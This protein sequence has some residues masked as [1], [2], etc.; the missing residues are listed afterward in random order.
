[1]EK[2]YS[3]KRIQNIKGVDK[4][5]PEQIIFTLENLQTLLQ[6]ANNVIEELKEYFENEINGR[7][8]VG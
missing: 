8:Y 7:D 5:K 6:E 3:R 2:I 1:M 4:L